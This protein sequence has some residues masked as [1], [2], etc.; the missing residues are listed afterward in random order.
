MNHRSY[1][2]NFWLAPQGRHRRVRDCPFLVRKRSFDTPQERSGEPLVAPAQ[3]N[4]EA[5][6][7]GQTFVEISL[8]LPP[9]WTARQSARKRTSSDPGTCGHERLAFGFLLQGMTKTRTHR[10]CFAGRKHPS[11]LCS[12]HSRPYADVEKTICGM[13]NSLFLKA[14]RLLYGKESGGL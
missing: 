5:S 4:I 12:P 11:A 3:R 6:G 14:L 7:I 2:W 9:K 10:N 1:C 13:R 8:L